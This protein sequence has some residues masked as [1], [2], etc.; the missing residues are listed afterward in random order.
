MT[1]ERP[2]SR[3]KKEAQLQSQSQVLSKS[4]QHDPLQQ[5]R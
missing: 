2:H 3:N 4:K 5:S 1:L